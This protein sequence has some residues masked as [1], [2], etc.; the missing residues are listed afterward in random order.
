MTIH[1][2]YSTSTRRNTT[3]RRSPQHREAPVE[4]T[5]GKHKKSTPARKSLNDKLTGRKIVKE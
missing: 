4:L 5:T 2:Y 3:I 1:D